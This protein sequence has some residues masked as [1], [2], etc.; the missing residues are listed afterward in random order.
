MLA[1]QD[2]RSR[3]G[4]LR[5]QR[6]DVS[7][8]IISELKRKAQ[9]T[10]SKL[11]RKTS[12]AQAKFESSLR[13][14]LDAI[15]AKPQIYA[16]F[17]DT[18]IPASKLVFQAENLNFRF[19]GA[20]APLWATPINLA[21]KGP[22]K[23][24]VTGGNGAGK[25]TFLKL[26]T[27]EPKL[28]GEMSGSLKLGNL[29][30]RFIDQSLEMIDR[31]KSVLENASFASSKNHALIR[32][33]LAQFLFT[34]DQVNQIAGTLSGGEK[35]RMALAMSLLADPVPQ[36]LILDEPTNNIDITNLEFME[37]AL[38][39]FKGALIVVSHDTTFLEHIGINC[40]LHL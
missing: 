14:S 39:K 2:K 11:D 28:T 37:A 22:L 38:E 7:K 33:L 25:S 40:W 36:L 20:P 16:E 15:K 23:V 32:N 31:S 1:R 27:G 5:A 17:P 4:K 34:G 19:H 8:E 35:L 9:I 24:A 21:V 26:L 12:D 13:E 10:S 30:Y 3:H 6:Q 18:E 29:D